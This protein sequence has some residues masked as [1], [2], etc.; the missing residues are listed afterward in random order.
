MGNTLMCCAPGPKTVRIHQEK[1]KIMEF[2]S[3]ILAS[4][5]MLQYPNH[6]IVYRCINGKPGT[7]KQSPSFNSK[8]IGQN[9]EVRVVRASTKL[10][11]GHAYFLVHIP[12]QYLAR[13]S[14]Y[15]NVANSLLAPAPAAPPQA[16]SLGSSAAAAAVVMAAGA[17]GKDSRNLSSNARVPRRKSSRPSKP[18]SKSSRH[19]RSPRGSPGHKKSSGR[20]LWGGESSASISPRKV[21]A[22]HDGSQKSSGLTYYQYYR[23]KYARQSWRP[24][25]STIS[26]NDES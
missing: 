20:G 3:P 19:R 7:I 21:C 9:A 12:E 4:K 26:E 25:L 11:L 14:K 6:L 15:F 5:L 2:Y 22:S 1:G 24:L 23:S 18:G 13:F 8:A 17:L 10:E 16:T